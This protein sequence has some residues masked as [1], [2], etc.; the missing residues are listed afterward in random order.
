MMRRHVCFALCAALASPAFAQLRDPTEPPA[1]LRAPAARAPG[2]AQEEIP[3]GPRLQSVLVSPK[4][5]VAVID[6]HAVQVGQKHRG[7]VVQSISPTQVIL[8]RGR[9]REVLKLYPATPGATAQGQR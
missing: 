1:A 9:A 7:A 4:R 6:G 2:E 3:A 5:R 8:V